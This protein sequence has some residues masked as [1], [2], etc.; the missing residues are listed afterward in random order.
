MRGVGAVRCKE[1]FD[2]LLAHA[3]VC[4]RDDVGDIQKRD[5]LLVCYRLRPL[6]ELS[7]AQTA[8]DFAVSPNVTNCQRQYNRMR[9]LG[10][11]V[12][13]KFANIPAEGV[14]QFRPAVRRGE[15]HCLIPDTW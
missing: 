12:L 5:T 14:D 9:T 4:V 2:L 13:N 8:L 6:A 10:L 7:L 11:D 15:P 3:L 1:R